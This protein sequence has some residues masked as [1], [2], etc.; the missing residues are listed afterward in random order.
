MTKVNAGE[1]VVSLTWL[2]IPSVGKH[3][4]SVSPVGIWLDVANGNM[5]EIKGRM[6]LIAEEERAGSEINASSVQTAV[7]TLWI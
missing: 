1:Q 7:V 6:M 5:I 4:A 2:Q 3:G